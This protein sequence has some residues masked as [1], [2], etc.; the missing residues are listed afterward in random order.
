MAR[1]L[2]VND[3]YRTF[4]KYRFCID[5]RDKKIRQL[6]IAPLNPSQAVLAGRRLTAQQHQF[7]LIDSE[8]LAD[9]LGVVTAYKAFMS[10]PESERNV[11]IPGV[12]FTSEQ[13]Y[14]VSGCLA[15]CGKEPAQRDPRYAARKFRC[16]VPLMNMPEFSSAFKCPL[17]SRMNPDNKCSFW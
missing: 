17:R 11:L 12:N 1:S 15:W 2:C 8:N 5:Y 4:K 14:F 10:L 6:R 16:N 13:Q 7:Q 3:A 9:F